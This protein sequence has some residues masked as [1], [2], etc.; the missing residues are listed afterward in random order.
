MK[1]ETPR[2]DDFD[3]LHG[4]EYD[5]QCLNFARKLE[6]ELN[7]QETMRKTKTVKLKAPKA[8]RSTD[9]VRRRLTAEEWDEAADLFEQ[10]AVQAEN[11]Y[12]THPAAACK[13]AIERM[14][15]LAMYATGKAMAERAK[16]K[17]SNARGE[18]PLTDGARTRQEV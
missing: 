17:A 1:S 13:Y 5:E 8:V 4:Y 16:A 18:R 11:S 3:K 14:N 2:T 10:G 9:M 6:R 15:S 7:N 12:E